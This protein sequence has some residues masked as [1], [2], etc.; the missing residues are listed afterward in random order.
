M[1]SPAQE[2]FVKRCKYLSERVNEES[3][4]VYGEFLTEVEMRER[5]FSE[6]LR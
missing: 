5:K 1:Q 2:H 6:L 3:L 4:E